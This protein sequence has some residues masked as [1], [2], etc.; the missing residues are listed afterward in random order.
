MKKT[1][2]IAFFCIF[3]MCSGTII[4]IATAGNASYSLIECGA[5]AP[6]TI[7]GKWTTTDEWTDS[8]RCPLSFNGVFGYDIDF[9]TYGIEWVIEPF[10][11]STND[12]G[13]IVQ[14]C[15]DELNE[16][17]SVPLVDDFKIEITGHTT[18]KLYKGTGTAWAEVTATEILWKDSVTTTPWNGVAHW[19]IEVKDPDKT[20]GNLITG[21]PP[22][23]MR[24]A[25][26][27]AATDKWS[28]WAPGGT[29]NA[30]S[31]WGLVSGYS[32]DPVPEGFSIIFVAALTTMTIVAAFSLKKRASL[33]KLLR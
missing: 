18:C 30:P 20:V 9:T 32:T 12:A 15:I 5:V 26:Y 11:D 25:Y 23:G 8:Y 29:A 3:M 6:A 2:F 28:D 21:A 13:D 27:D 7:D 22:N 1:A 33:P 14:I 10:F 16:G 19:V 4:G 17:G 24:V 31:S